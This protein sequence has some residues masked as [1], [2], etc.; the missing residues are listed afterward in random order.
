VNEEQSA[1]WKEV[2]W[3]ANYV[4]SGIYF[5]KLIALQ[6]DGGQAGR[7]VEVKKMIL[8]K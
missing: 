6:K 7:F 1:G 8:L 5:Y 2:K 4:S 3:N